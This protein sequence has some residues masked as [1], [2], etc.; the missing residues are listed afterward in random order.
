MDIWTY[1][2]RY[3]V[4][5]IIEDG[6]L[7]ATKHPEGYDFNQNARKIGLNGENLDTTCKHVVSITTVVTIVSAG[8]SSHI[9]YENET[10]VHMVC[11]EGSLGNNHGSN[12]N[13][14][15]T[16]PF[17]SGDDRGGGGTSTPNG[18]PY[19]PPKVK[20]PLILKKMKCS[21]LSNNHNEPSNDQW[22]FRNSNYGLTY[23][24]IISQRENR[25]WSFMNSQQ[26]GPN[27]R[28]ISDPLNPKIIIDL[29]H[30]LIVGK[31]GRAAGESIEI[32]QWIKNDPSGYD[33]QD[34]YSN[35]LGYSF[36]QHYGE[37]IKYNPNAIA[38]YLISFLNNP[39]FR[40]SVS[41][42]ERCK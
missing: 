25:S 11:S 32:V 1:D 27:I 36:F 15:I 16:Y 7:T 9:S 37:A 12:G 6:Q 2:E 14:G 28:Y 31:L 19:T 24:E 17:N 13:T 33:D 10:S 30:L 5:F 21:D 20:A 3:F 23:N 29:R 41:S 42:P 26:G 34:F 18:Q 39:K 35:E 8:G 40:N 4:G 22:S 38:D